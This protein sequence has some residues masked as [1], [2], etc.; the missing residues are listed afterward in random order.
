MKLTLKVV[1]KQ[2]DFIKLNLNDHTV[3]LT[4]L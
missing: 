3:L 2:S 4:D 1:N